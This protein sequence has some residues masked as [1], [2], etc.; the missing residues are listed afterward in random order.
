MPDD[1]S[2]ELDVLMAA[3]KYAFEDDGELIS[4]HEQIMG[5]T[6]S[7]DGGAWFAVWIA[8]AKGFIATVGVLFAKDIHSVAK[9]AIRRIRQSQTGDLIVTDGEVQAVIEKDLTEE[10][11]HLLSGSLPDAPSGEIRFDRETGTWVDSTDRKA[12]EE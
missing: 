8:G 2:K 7:A 9:D 12:P 5:L 11:I 1:A 4:I 6:A 3:T 10:Q